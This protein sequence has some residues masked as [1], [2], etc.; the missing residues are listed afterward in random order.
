MNSE[1]KI[2]S[3]ATWTCLQT[4]RFQ[5]LEDGPLAI[6]VAMDLSAKFLLLSDIYRKNVYVMQLKEVRKHK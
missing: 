1:L 2:W 3:C 6:K 4:I 5:P